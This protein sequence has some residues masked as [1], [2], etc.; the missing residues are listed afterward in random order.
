[1]SP[2]YLGNL[3]KAPFKL[4]SI[5]PWGKKDKLDFLEK[6]SSQWPQSSAPGDPVNVEKSQILNIMLSISS[7]F[8]TP[9]EFTLNSWA[10]Y[11]GD[12]SGP[13]ANH[14]IQSFLNRITSTTSN[15]NFMALENIT[16]LLL[17]QENDSF[18]KRDIFSLF[19][20]KVGSEASPPGTEKTSPANREI[21]IA[22]TYN[23]IQ[24][25]G[26]D[27]YYF[28]CPSIAG[29][30]AAG[31]LSRTNKSTA[32]RILS[33]TDSSLY[34]ETMRYFSVFNKIE[35][36]LGE[37]LADQSLY[38]EK[39]IHVCHWLPY[40]MMPTVEMVPVLKAITAEI[41]NNKIY[42]VKLRLMI[43]LTKSGNANINNIVRHLLKSQNLKTKRAA[44][45]CAG[46]IQD[47][48]SVPLLIN[49]LNDPF[50]Y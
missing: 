35:P 9:L 18:S 2:T 30:L 45:I 11:A 19:S 3:I 41:H 13:K 22:L 20:K 36:Y 6:W 50:T 17:D 27:R 44:A 38:K 43:A 24:K 40:S 10:A 33:K 28:S 5:S 25:A 31:G 46:Y 12:L 49:Q 16:V 15:N 26:P 8:F 7:Q 21:Q 23:I 29:F 42:L 47:L 32:H 1:A 14:A 37:F 4:V 34:Y 48:G 39:L